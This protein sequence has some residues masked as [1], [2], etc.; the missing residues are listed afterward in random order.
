MPEWSPEN[1]TLRDVNK[2]KNKKLDLVV[3]KDFYFP[4]FQI[5]CYDSKVV[6]SGA[7]VYYELISL[8]FLTERVNT[9]VAYIHLC[10]TFW[11]GK[12]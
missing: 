12:E 9:T 4:V 11:V 10:L 8:G 3:V 7:S 6:L 1:S 5:G 2:K